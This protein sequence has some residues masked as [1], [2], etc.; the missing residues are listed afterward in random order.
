MVLIGFLLLAAAAAVGIDVAVENDAALNIDAFGQVFSTT[1]GGVFVAGA[2]AGIAASL[3]VM[4][5]RD[6]AA[7]RRTVRHETRREAHERD[8]LAAA[9]RAEHPDLDEADRD[10]IDLRDREPERAEQ[11]HRYDRAR[12]G[13]TSF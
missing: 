6:G 5:L 7:H 11:Y 8:R 13:V 3:A 12:Q 4:I 1:P 9:Y 10:G 2:V